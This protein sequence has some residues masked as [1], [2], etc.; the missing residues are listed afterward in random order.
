M[1]SPNQL[2]LYGALL[3]VHKISWPG[4]MHTYSPD[5]YALFGCMRFAALF[6][7]I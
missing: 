3:K 2:Q 1:Q 6:F 4:A 5:Y 7:A